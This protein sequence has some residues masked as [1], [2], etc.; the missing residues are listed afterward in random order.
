[1]INIVN[2]NPQSG[3]NPQYKMLKR[4]PQINTVLEHLNITKYED[5]ARVERPDA[6]YA[7]IN[8]TSLNNTIE[9]LADNLLNNFNH[10]QKC[11]NHTKYNFYKKENHI[12]NIKI[13]ATSQHGMIFP[14]SEP[15]RPYA[16]D[17]SIYKIVCDNCHRTEEINSDIY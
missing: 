1:M 10:K 8:Y 2:L 17:V 4:S 13:P 7:K 15:N 12:K 6:S 3:G 9:P 14:H 16:K 11:T 5:N